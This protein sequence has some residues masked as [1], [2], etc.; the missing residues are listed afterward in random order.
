MTQQQTNNDRAVEALER[1][2]KHEQEC[3]E[4]WLEALI[5]LR[6]LRKASDAFAARWERLAWLVITTTL[7]A[8]ATVVTS[9]IL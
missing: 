9:L 3:S 6:S 1:I 2:A 7:A 4:R 8:I 5:E